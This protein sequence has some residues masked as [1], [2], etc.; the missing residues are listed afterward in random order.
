MRR[1]KHFNNN[2]QPKK[3]DFPP[4]RIKYSGPSNVKYQSRNDT[5]SHNSI[6][7]Q[8]TRGILKSGIH[9]Y[10]DNTQS[11]ISKEPFE[12]QSRREITTPKFNNFDEQFVSGLVYNN[13]ENQFRRSKWH[14]IQR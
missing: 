5:G 11:G 1:F 10:N 7:N 14:P 3:K 13:P 4:S 8:S 6:Q 2:I 9:N 12:R